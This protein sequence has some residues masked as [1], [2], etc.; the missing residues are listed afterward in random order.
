MLKASAIWMITEALGVNLGKDRIYVKIDVKNL[1]LPL[2][3]TV[4]D[5]TAVANKISLQ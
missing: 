5:R 1:F 4:A 3:V 2:T